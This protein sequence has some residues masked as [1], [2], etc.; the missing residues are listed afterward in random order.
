MGHNLLLSKE[1]IS[2]HL[3]ATIGWTIEEKAL[4]KEFKFNDF[5]S[6][7]VFM[8]RVAFEA[9]H[10][11]HHPNWTYVYNSVTIKWSTHEAGGI[12]ALDFELAKKTDNIFD[13][14]F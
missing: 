4:A 7:F 12:T 3:S 8:T 11:N 1:E 6:A 14:G 10:L 2:Q 9:E 5:K 13:H